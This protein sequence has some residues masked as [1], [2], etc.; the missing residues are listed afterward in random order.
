MVRVRAGRET[1]HFPPACLCGT[2]DFMG[3][4][5]VEPR[6]QRGP[7]TTGKGESLNVR[8][9]PTEMAALDAWIAKQREELSRPEAIRRLVA[10]GLKAKAGRR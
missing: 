6:K 10:A 7:P 5:T 1:A 3:K 8:L 4:Q 2:T 9:Q